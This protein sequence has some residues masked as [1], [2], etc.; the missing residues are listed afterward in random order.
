MRLEELGQLNK[1][2]D[3]FGRGH[4][5]T[6]GPNEGRTQREL[7]QLVPEGIQRVKV[8]LQDI[9][10][11]SAQ[12]MK[13]LNAPRLVVPL[14]QSPINRLP[15]GCADTQLLKLLELSL[16]SQPSFARGYGLL[17]AGAQSALVRVGVGSTGD[18]N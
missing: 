11:R 18:V 2:F 13:E 7:G 12:K 14:C 10:L 15:H 6:L 5:G 8:V 1:V 17:Q 4:G 9:E 16:V 3:A